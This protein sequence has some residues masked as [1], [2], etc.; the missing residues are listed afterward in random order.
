VGNITVR[1]KL[2]DFTEDVSNANQTGGIKAQDNA[3]F[4][5]QSQ[6]YGQAILQN[7]R[8]RIDSLK[9]PMAAVS[10]IQP[11]NP[12]S[13]AVSWPAVLPAGTNSRNRGHIAS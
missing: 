1:P 13:V 11:E 8:W 4:G 10:P 3:A 5:A 7:T 2:Q 9:A 6:G 12:F